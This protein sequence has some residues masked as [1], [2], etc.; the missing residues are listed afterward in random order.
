MKIYEWENNAKEYLTEAG[1]ILIRRASDITK[2]LSAEHVNRI[3]I[4]LD[5]SRDET[6]RLSIEK[7]YVPIK[8]T[9][10]K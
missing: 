4:T 8:D 7:E 9:I 2:D 10:E 5:I 1:R 6:P 3:Y